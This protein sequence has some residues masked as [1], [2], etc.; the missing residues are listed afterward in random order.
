M[1]D[2]NGKIRGRRARRRAAAC[3]AAALML[4]AAPAMAARSNV[5]PGDAF[6][7]TYGNTLPPIGFVDFCARYRAECRPA[8]HAAGLLRLT[9]QRWR[10]LNEV[11]RFVNR[12]VRPVTD[13]QLFNRPE[14]WEYPTNAG[15]CEDYV[16]LKKRYLEGLGFAP[17]TLLITVVLDEQ[18]GGHAVLM[19]RTDRG[20]YVLDNRRNAILL[21][22][23]TGYTY[24]KRQSQTNPA[25][26]VSLTRG[27]G[28]K[29]RYYGNNR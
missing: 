1:V 22:N 18:G 15:D 9:R 2:N 8:G 4:A 21:W 5:A 13:Q 19:V 7:E 29:A 28:G 12:K 20:D 6:A 23:R 25:Q 3:L 11:N 14:V 17:G 10:L 26:W 16:L 24:L 27:R